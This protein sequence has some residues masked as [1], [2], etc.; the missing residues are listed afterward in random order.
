LYRIYRIIAEHRG[1][2]AF[3]PALTTLSFSTEL[4]QWQNIGATDEITSTPASA[5]DHA[6]ALRADAT[7]A[8]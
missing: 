7:G 4:C 2:Q 5:E 1:T 3:A 6:D 8:V